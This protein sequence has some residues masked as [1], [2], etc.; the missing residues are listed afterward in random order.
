LIRE[1]ARPPS[2][3]KKQYGGW[4]TIPDRRPVIAMLV[5]GMLLMLANMSIEPIITVYVAQLVAPAQVTF[6]AGLVMSAA[7]FGSVLSASRLGKLADRIGAWNV[8]IACLTVSAVLLI[9]QAFVTAG[10]QL[11]LL[12]FLMGLAL[13]GLLPCIASVIRH[14]VPETV[15]GRMLGW[16]VSSQYTGQV[17]GPLMGGFVGGHLG[18]RAVFLGTSV[19]LVVG[20]VGNWVA[21]ARRLADPAGLGRTPAG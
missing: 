7:A 6:V 9:P 19:L 11:V 15:S 2:A 18:M 10:W 14:N 5:T 21:Q 13:G 16:S 3:A 8:I 1:K 20:A 4:D 12:R 17:V